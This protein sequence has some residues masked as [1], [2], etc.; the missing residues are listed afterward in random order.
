MRSATA[1]LIVMLSLGAHALAD[2]PLH[3]YKPRGGYVPNAQTAIRIAVAVWEPIY[4]RE[5]IERQ[6]PIRAEL[7]DGVWYVAGSLPAGGK[8]G[9]AEAEVAKG[10]GRI[11]RISHGK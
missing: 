1:S 3:N 9:V 2:E 11:I 8:G 4:G 6:K 10:D 7:K 5:N